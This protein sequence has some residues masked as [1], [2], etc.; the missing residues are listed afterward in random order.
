MV[1]D[2]FLGVN[3]N[4]SNEI[5]KIYSCSMHNGT[6]LYCLE[7]DND[8]SLYNYN[9]DFLQSEKLWNNSCTVD[10]NGITCGEL[11]TKTYNAGSPRTTIT[12]SGIITHAAFN[13]GNHRVICQNNRGAAVCMIRYLING[14]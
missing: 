4:S 12:T 14:G 7:G 10:S 3:V 5:T 11:S 1:G 8:G 13:N 6:S 9:K 2:F